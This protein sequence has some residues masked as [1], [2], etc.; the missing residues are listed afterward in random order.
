MTTKIK[1]EE[2]ETQLIC[3]EVGNSLLTGSTEG[4]EENENY[5]LPNIFEEFG[6]LF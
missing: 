2:P 6:G 1:Y 3:L 4:G 5:T